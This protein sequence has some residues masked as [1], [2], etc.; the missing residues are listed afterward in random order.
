MQ[1]ISLKRI[2][3]PI[4]VNDGYRIYVDRLYPRGLPRE[5]FVCDEW[6]NDL[7]PSAGLRHWFHGDPENRWREFEERYKEELN[8][9]PSFKNLRERLE[10]KRHITLLYSSRNEKYNNAV[11]MEEELENSK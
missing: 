10:D 7:A 5:K 8:D 6:I 3:D 4:D 2:Y 9:N 11:V 1:K